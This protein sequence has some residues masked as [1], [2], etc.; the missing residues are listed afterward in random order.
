MRIAKPLTLREKAQ[1]DT[2]NERLDARAGR[3][4]TVAGVLGGLGG[5]GMSGWLTGTALASGGSS[6]L[7]ESLPALRGVEAAVGP[8]WTSVLVGGVLFG[9]GM[10]LVAWRMLRAMRAARNAL[11][12]RYL[13]AGA[14]GEPPR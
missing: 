4:Y 14:E 6:T 9:G 13:A 8:L 7:T 3:V 10:L 1:L 5:A 2:W 12:A 11:R